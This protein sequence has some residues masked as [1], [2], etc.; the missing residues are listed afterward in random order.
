MNTP[1]SIQDRSR[2]ITSPTNALLKV[3]RRALAEGRT[4]DGWVAIEGARLVEEAIR[5]GDPKAQGPQGQLCALRS[6]LV[7]ESAAQKFLELLKRVP[8]EAEIVQVPDDLFR[9]ISQTESPQ[10]IAALVERPAYDLDDCLKRESAILMVACGLQDPGNLGA[11]LR[12]SD[13]LGATAALTVKGTVSLFNPKV[14]RSSGGALFRL[15]VFPAVDLSEL[16]GRLREAGVRTIAAD[17][18]VGI[19]LP[20]TDLRGRVAL[21]IGSEA[22]GVSPEIAKQVSTRVRIP[23]KPGVDSVNAAVAASVF[24][25]EVQRQRGFDFVPT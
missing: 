20:E 2:R 16:L 5:C 17:S 4:H 9:K 19:S 12:T 18:T 6:L 14:V 11:I 23:M 21:F 25:Y 3:F 13:A 7:G 22:T 10:G 1:S 24:L 15:P 8:R